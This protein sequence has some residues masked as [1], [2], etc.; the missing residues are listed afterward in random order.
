ML[1]AYFWALVKSET[2]QRP[3]HYHVTQDAH[4]EHH[5]LVPI[6]APALDV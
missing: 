6:I 5:E 1:L 3:L 4:H 2:D